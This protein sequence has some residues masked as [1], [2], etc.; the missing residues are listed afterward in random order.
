MRVDIVLFDDPIEDRE[1][2]MAKQVMKKRDGKAIFIALSGNIHSRKQPPP[3]RP[4][5]VPA[6]AHLVAA[7][8]PVKTFD[9]SANG[10]TFWGCVSTDDHEPVCGVH[11]NGKGA[12]GKPWTLGP[13]PDAAHDGLYFVGT[14]N[15][16]HPARS[17]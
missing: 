8:L 10:G 2:A 14:T 9:A 13:A 11:E 16:S 7:K 15:A 1:R 6:V 3:Q 17:R 12:D 5:L 4:D